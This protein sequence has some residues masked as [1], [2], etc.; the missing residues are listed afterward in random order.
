MLLPLIVAS[1][2]GKPLTC[3]VYLTFLHFD[4]GSQAQLQDVVSFIYF[5]FKCYSGCQEFKHI[6]DFDELFL[7]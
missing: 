4:D 7:S 3:F 6:L 1:N 2:S 5:L